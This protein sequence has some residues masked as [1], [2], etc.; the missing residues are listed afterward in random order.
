MLEA[1]LFGG[2]CHCFFFFFSWKRGLPPVPGCSARSGVACSESGSAKGRPAF[3]T[4][5]PQSPS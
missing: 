5:P 2:L 4:R 1:V 3:G